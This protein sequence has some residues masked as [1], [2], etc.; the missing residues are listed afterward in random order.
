MKKILFLTNPTNDSTEEDVFVTEQLKKYY[1]LVVVHPLQCEQY[2][3]SVQAVVIRN[4]WPTYEYLE[5]LKRIKK[6]IQDSKKPVHNP[7]CGRGDM[8]G[9]DYL[10]GLY[11]SSFPVIPS[12]DRVEDIGLLPET[13]LYWIKPKRSCSGYGAEK[14]SKEE[15][16]KRKLA[17]YIIQPYIDFVSEPSFFFI[18]NKFS[19]AIEMPNR[20]NDRNITL[21]TPTKEDFVFAQRFVAWNTL[22]YGIQRIDAVRT[23]TGKLLL[24]EV[25]DIAEYL[26]LLDIEVETRD[27]VVAELIQSIQNIV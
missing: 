12:V 9:K 14:L 5:E 19:Y 24:T 20:L 3:D 16:S 2:L 15:L 1:D 26:Y 6:L 25:E 23:K 11:K 22:P 13:S 27:R 17:D 8:E 18:D 21:Y 7:L 10:I 4:M